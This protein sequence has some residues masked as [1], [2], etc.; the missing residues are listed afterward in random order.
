MPWVL[1]PLFGIVF[2]LAIPLTAIFFNHQQRMAELRKGH[3]EA[4][5]SAEVQMLRREIAELK[6]LVHEQAIAVDNLASRA[7]PMIPERS[8]ECSKI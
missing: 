7:L 8:N 1:I 3:G 5:P 2:A 6:A 4:L